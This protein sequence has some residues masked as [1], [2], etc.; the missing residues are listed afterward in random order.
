MRGENFRTIRS[1]RF[2]RLVKRQ[3][4]VVSREQLLELGYSAKAI[5]HRLRVGRLHR[6]WR[7]VYAVGRYE[8]SED[9]RL[10]AAVLSCGP[11]SVVSHESAAFRWKLKDRSPSKIDLSV[12]EHVRRSREGIVLHRRMDLRP[13]EIT[14]H[15][16]IPV[17]T[18]ACTIFDLAA[19][20]PAGRVEG[21]ISQADKLG[22]TT[23][24][25]LR[26]VLKSIGPRP[27]VGTVRGILNRLTFRLT[28]SELE[29]KFLRLVRR[30]GLPLP[31]TGRWLNGFKVDFFWPELGLIVETDGLRY[32]RNEAQQALDRRRDQT[33]VAAGLTTL[34]FT[35]SQV[36]FEPE[37]VIAT[38]RTVAARLASAS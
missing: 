27:G 15:H 22:L 21:A 31:E 11:N 38:L 23:P 17:T 12:P 28:D 36:T 16:G 7:G 35:H 34:R 5:E 30:A 10:M 20:L 26:G 37:H 3:H 19:R 24:A 14:S 13:D 4:G 9:G 25:E 6:I 2:W 33:H 32:H 18:P 29:R 8:L 1:R